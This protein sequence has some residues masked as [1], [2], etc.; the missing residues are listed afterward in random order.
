[1]MG[2]AD[3]DAVADVLN[4]AFTINWPNYKKGLALNALR[5]FSV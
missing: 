5:G 3:L 4:P 2:V 1:M